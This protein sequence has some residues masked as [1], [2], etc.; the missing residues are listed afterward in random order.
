MRSE[1]DDISPAVRD[2]SIIRE[3]TSQRFDLAADFLKAAQTR[4]AADGRPS[5][6]QALGAL[7][8]TFNSASA[9]IDF[10]LFLDLMSSFLALGI[11]EAASAAIA[12]RFDL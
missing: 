8:A 3:W 1:D 10:I 11:K 12:K 7:A 5:A 9:F 6:A 2:L 4:C